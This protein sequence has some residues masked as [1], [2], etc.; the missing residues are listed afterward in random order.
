MDTFCQLAPGHSND[1]M[2]VL[3]YIAITHE[4]ACAF[5][6][7]AAVTVGTEIKVSFTENE[8]VRKETLGF[9]STET[10]NAY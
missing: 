5:C 6:V 7:V 1:Q 4:V 10:I 8:G 3:K 2:F 9:T